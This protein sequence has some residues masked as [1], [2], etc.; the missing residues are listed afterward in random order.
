MVARVEHRRTIGYRAVMATLQ[1][2][3]ATVGYSVEGADSG[4]PLL[5]LHGTT[6]TRSA[7]DAVRAAMPG[8]VYRFTLIEL[9]GSGESSM[10]SEPLTVAGVVEQSLALMTHLG[11][12]TFHVG[13]FS[14]GAVIALAIAG[15]S[16]ERVLS[17]TSLCG[18]AVSD[19]RMRLTFELWKRLIAADPELFMRYA[20]A[21]GF[22]VAAL[23]VAEPIIETLLPFTASQIAP[24][25][26]AHLDLDIT[27]DISALLASIAAPALIIGATEDRWVDVGN[28]RAL[29]SAIPGSKLHELPAGHLVIQE[30]AVEVAA[31][32]HAHI[33]A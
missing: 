4:T 26:A 27:L 16:P 2:G 12:D 28:S 14:L 33:A 18:W 10:P 20:M 6:M 8:D 24:G 22:T 29:H 7:W 1:V 3:D 31:L 30:L 13:G 11:H 17:V 9:P 32:L 23:T 21:D 25:S 15:T 19:A 5:L